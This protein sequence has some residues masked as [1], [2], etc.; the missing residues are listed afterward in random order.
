M[1]TF[2][3]VLLFVSLFLEYKKTLEYFY[4]VN[5]DRWIDETR[6]YQMSV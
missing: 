6:I 4:V 2:L 3:S 1:V 5:L